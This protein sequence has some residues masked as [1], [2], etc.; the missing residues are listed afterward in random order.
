MKPRY[1]LPACP[2]LLLSLVL[3]VVVLRANASRILLVSAQF[4]SHQLELRDLGI[5]LAARG[6]EVWMTLETDHPTPQLVAPRPLHIVNYSLPKDAARLSDPIYHNGLIAI[7]SSESL[8]MILV[9]RQTTEDN[10]VYMIRDAAFISRLERLR[11][12]SSSS[13][14]SRSVT[15]CF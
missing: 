3:S 6:H 2:S 15:V 8:K 4:T 10:C 7:P 12:T 14:A 5:S 13:T 1:R 9:V 11:L